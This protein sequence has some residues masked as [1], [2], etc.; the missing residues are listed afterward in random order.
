MPLNLIKELNL[1]ISYNFFKMHQL[2]LSAIL[3]IVSF[4]KLS[5]CCYA[6]EKKRKNKPI[7]KCVIKKEIR[8]IFLSNFAI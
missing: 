1:K 6:R 3:F 7:N 5:M 4:L 8:Q 2:T